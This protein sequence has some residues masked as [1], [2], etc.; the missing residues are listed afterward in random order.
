MSPYFNITMLFRY[1]WSRLNFIAVLKINSGLIW[2]LSVLINALL[3]VLRSMIQI[4]STSAMRESGS[5][6]NSGMQSS[7][8]P[9][10]IK[11]EIMQGMAVGR[12]M[13]ASSEACRYR[14]LPWILMSA[15]M[16]GMT[17]WW[18]GAHLH[19]SSAENHEDCERLFRENTGNVHL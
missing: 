16:D 1:I 3:Y 14:S 12:Q 5:P 11:K 9:T 10:D 2:E 13:K 15:Q 4:Y 17:I 6:V 7:H 8:C 19:T 18:S